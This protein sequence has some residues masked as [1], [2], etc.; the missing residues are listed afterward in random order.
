MTNDLSMKRKSGLTRIY[1]GASLAILT[2][3]VAGLP[4]HGDDVPEFMRVIS[5]DGKP[6]SELPVAEKNVLGVGH[7]DDGYLRRL[8]GQVQPEHA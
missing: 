3:A 2:V 5:A 8:A 7:L 1:R 6:A 4:V